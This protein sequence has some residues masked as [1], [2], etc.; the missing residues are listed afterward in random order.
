M[1]GASEI[2][3][4]PKGG[5]ARGYRLRAVVD[6]TGA[7]D[8]RQASC[9]AFAAVLDRQLNDCVDESAT[10]YGRR[11]ESASAESER[12]PGRDR[13]LSKIGDLI[14]YLESKYDLTS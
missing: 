14:A 13:G 2:S 3:L 8:S 6:A 1:I 9:R 11:V 7:A 4:A 5:K 10:V 12:P